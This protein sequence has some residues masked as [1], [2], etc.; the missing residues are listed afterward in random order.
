[1]NLLAHPILDGLIDELL[2]PDPIQALELLRHDDRSKMLAAVARSRMACMQMGLVDH[3]EMR[4]AERF[5]ELRFEDVAHD[6]VL[7]QTEDSLGD[8]VLLDIGCS[9]ADY[10][11]GPVQ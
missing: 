9:A 2:R 3:F 7:G 5:T 4:R 8:D 10:D 6:S 11:L 1:M